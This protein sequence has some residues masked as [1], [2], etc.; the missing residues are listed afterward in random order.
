MDRRQFLS[1]SAMTCLGAARGTSA[2]TGLNTRDVRDF[3]IAFITDIYDAPN[4]STAKARIDSGP[5]TP[6]QQYTERGG[7]S[8]MQMP[9]HFSL[10]TDA[11]KLTTGK[12]HVTVQVTWPDGTIVTESTDFTVVTQETLL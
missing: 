12:H 9:H 3:D 10:S 8:K 4:G 1:L 2:A 5:W 6:M 11:A 7:Y